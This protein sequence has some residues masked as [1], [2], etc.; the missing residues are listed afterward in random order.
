LVLLTTAAV[1][2]FAF[3]AQRAGMTYLG[4]F[5][6]QG[7]R[8][9]LGALVLLPVA[10]GLPRLLRRAAARPRATHSPP[11]GAA[12]GATPRPTAG[13]RVLARDGV[14]VGLLLFGGSSFQQVGLQYTTAGN[15]GFIT[16]LYVVIVPLIG[17][18]WGWRTGPRRWIAAGVA[19]VGLYLLAVRSGINIQGGDALIALCSVF[20]AAHVVALSRI[21]RRHNPLWL[22]VV[23]Y[24][25]CG[26]VSI[27]I[28]A[29][30]E[31]MSPEAIARSW[32]PIAYGGVMSVGIAYSLQI[33][34]Q[35]RAH[36][37]HAAIILSLEGAFAALGGWL[38]LAEVLTA[39]EAVGAAIMLVAMLTSQMNGSWWRVPRFLRRRRSPDSVGLQ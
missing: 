19:V 14:I 20:F 27:C 22:A 12:V 39:R 34:G 32:A 21:A 6:Y 10:V 18:L 5:S 33:V 16:G 23:Q 11:A 3:V 26:V 4:P 37:A 29:L 9:L 31:K 7:L 1:W 30:F 8:F 24:A 13:W 35:R 2:G 17:G 25:V 36:P 28:A 38:V 15:A